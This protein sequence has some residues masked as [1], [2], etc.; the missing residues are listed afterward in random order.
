VAIK[1]QKKSEKQLDLEIS[2]LDGKVKPLFRLFLKLC[3]L[4]KQSFLYLL[5]LQAILR[6]FSAAAALDGCPVA[7]LYGQIYAPSQI[8]IDAIGQHE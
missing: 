5:C 1:P 2:R 6:S 4:R 8:R 3:S 7:P